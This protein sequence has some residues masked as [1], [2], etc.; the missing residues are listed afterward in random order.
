MKTI[1]IALI[2]LFAAFGTLVAQPKHGGGPPAARIKEA[3]KQFLQQELA[4]DDAKMQVFW[5]VYETYDQEKMAVR[6]Q[7]KKLK[8]GFNAKSDAELSQDIDK[9]FALK[10]QELAIDKKYRKKF[11]EVLTIRQ[12]AVLYQSEH[13]FKKWLLEQIKERRGHGGTHIPEDED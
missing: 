10:D 8:Q 6:E 5:K 3:K 2:S 7:M 9:F 4:L 13:H 12:V 11:Q 1:A